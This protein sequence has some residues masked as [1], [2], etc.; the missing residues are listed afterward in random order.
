[1]AELQV[2]SP[3]YPQVQNSPG[4]LIPVPPPAPVGNYQQVV[5]ASIAAAFGAPFK[6]PFGGSPVQ[7]NRLRAYC[8]INIDGLSGSVDVT[9]RLQPFLLSVR[10]RN[11]IGGVSDYTAEI[12]LDDRDARLPIPPL[13]AHVTIDLGWISENAYQVFDG[14]VQDVEHGFARKQGGRRMWIQCSG[15]NHMGAGK[16]PMQG[17]TGEGAQGGENEGSPIKILDALTKAAGNAGHSFQIAPKFASLTRDY[18]SQNNESFYHFGNRIADEIGGFFRV[19][20]GTRAMINAADEMADGA[21]PTVIA[22][23]GYNL[24]SWKVHPMMARPAWSG[25]NQQFFDHLKGQ[26]NTIA[27][28]VGMK[29]PWGAVTSLFALP[30]P[31]ANASNADQDNSGQ[32]DGIAAGT[33]PGRIVINGEPR[34][35]G[36]GYVQLSGARPGVDGLYHI[37]TAEHLYSREGYVTWLDVYIM[38][39]GSGSTVDGTQYKIASRDNPPLAPL[40]VLGPLPPPDN[41]QIGPTPTPAV[42]SN[43]PPITNT[44]GGFSPTNTEQQSLVAGF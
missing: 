22:Q 10:V 1:M 26:W 18:V 33:G 12:E 9:S 8:K 40:P 11:G 4:L 17:H 19:V 38:T 24:I 23:W 36:G 31:A 25:S 13:G 6:D 37:D 43:T 41:P 16:D 30:Q 21:Y 20:G 29:S 44:P 39:K 15:E 5:D 42:S 28:Q 14:T 3:G 7:S 32:A 34:A 2:N 35:K 27:G